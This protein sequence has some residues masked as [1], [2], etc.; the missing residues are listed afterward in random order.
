MCEHAYTCG[1]SE[2]PSTPKKTLNLRF[3]SIAGMDGGTAMVTSLNGSS[4]G[5]GTNSPP[6]PAL[7]VALLPL[8]LVSFGYACGAQPKRCARVIN[9]S[10][11]AS[12]VD[13]GRTGREAVVLSPRMRDLTSFLVCELQALAVGRSPVR[14]QVDS[15]S[16]SPLLSPACVL[17]SPE[18][19][20]A[21][22]QR[23]TQR[24]T[25]ALGTRVCA[26]SAAARRDG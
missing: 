10:N 15:P 17:A 6:S 20:L 22:S 18:G 25:A 11:L 19:G 4:S 14:R 13:A 23:S 26:C 16:A 21:S 8:E 12:A 1:A 2:H 5:E 24:P 9:C 3:V 7:E